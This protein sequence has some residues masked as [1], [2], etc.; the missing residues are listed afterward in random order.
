MPTDEVSQKVQHIAA[1]FDE[2]R[3][4]L[5]AMRSPDDDAASDRANS[6]IRELDSLRA[7]FDA[8]ADWM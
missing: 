5:E 4:L 3:Q 8:L 7:S 2:L 1:E 6:A